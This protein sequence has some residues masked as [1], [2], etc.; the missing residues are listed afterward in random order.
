MLVITD[1]KNFKC[2]ALEICFNCI[3]L[4]KYLI[5]VCMSMWEYVQMNSGPYN[6]QKV[7]SDLLEMKP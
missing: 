2:I 1:Y 6:G 4:K 3:F 7:E 5:Y